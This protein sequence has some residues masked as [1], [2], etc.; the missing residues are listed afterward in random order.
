MG[1]G[2]TGW[3]PVCRAMQ[4][5]VR[6]CMVHQQHARLS[7][8]GSRGSWCLIVQLVLVLGV[9]VGQIAQPA[10]KAHDNSVHQMAAASITTRM[11]ARRTAWR[12]WM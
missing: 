11:H 6:L 7:E 12:T 4:C 9:D 2:C 1:S 5:A 8:A 10:S 3:N